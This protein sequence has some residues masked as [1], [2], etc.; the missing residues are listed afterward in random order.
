[1]NR[2]SFLSS[3]LAAPLAGPLLS[4]VNAAAAAKPK[5]ILVRSLWQTVNIGDIAHGPGMLQLLAEQL[6]D[7][8][9]TLWPTK[10]D[11]GV[12]A[13]LAKNFPNVKIV[14]GSANKE[15]GEQNSPE[16]KEAFAEC[17]YFLH[18]SGPGL[19][20]IA[21]LAAWKKA[22]GK[23]YGIYAVTLSQT[24]VKTHR[25]LL[26]GADF[27]FTRDTISLGVA[28]DAGLKT[29]VM[30]FAP[31][32]AFAF[33]LRDDETALPY[34]REH[35]LEEGKFLCVLPR[36]RFSP[37]WEIHNKPMTDEDRRRQKVN[38]EW[39]E[40]DH[41]KAREAIVAFVRGGFGKV[42]LCPEMTDQVELARAALF[43]P[44]PD[45][46]K[47]QVVWR[48]KYWRPDEAASVYARALG[49]VSLEQHSPIFAINSG[50]PAIHLRQST[51]T[52]KGQMW[53][54]VGLN[55]WIFE[56]DEEKDGARIAEATVAIAKDP[57]AAKAKV[58]KAQDLILQRQ[59]ETVGVLAK[60]LAKV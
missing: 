53:R 34:L 13:M 41:S 45:D 12:D 28:R 6:P 57:A 1:M 33:R 59:K 17:D 16:L 30:D 42:L 9:I 15:T 55:D 60:N 22:T 43:E 44:L 35:G 2:R 10:V 32:G 8:K 18:G 27:L 48:D 14:T 56:M 40:R 46:V 47:K 3:I 49:M 39:R 11:R 31:D 25:E 58:K 21:H 36:Q 5:R 26:D 7:A 37:Y 38:E 23:P 19:V 20:A 50:V 54:D 24:E 4:A 51:A 52:S 29:P